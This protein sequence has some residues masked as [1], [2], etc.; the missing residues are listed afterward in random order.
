MLFPISRRD[1]IRQAGAAALAGTASAAPA[2]QWRNR[3]TSMAYR[4][5][6]RTGLMISEVVSGGDPIRSDNWNHLELALEMGLNYLDMAPGYGN[7]DCEVAYGKLLGGSSARREKVFLTTKISGLTGLRNRLYKEIFDG[8]PGARQEALR[9]RA[10]DL[11]RERGIAKP[12]YLFEY[13]PGQ[14]GQIA[15]SYLT[16]AMQPDYAHKVDGSARFREFIVKS[17]EGSLQR[18]RTDYFDIVMCPHGAL[19]PEELDMPEIIETFRRLQQQGKVRFLG[20]TSHTDP[21]G[22]LRRAAALGHYDCAM[23][24]YNV[25]NG[26][27]LEHAIQEAVARGM[28][29]VA[30][31]VAM[32]VATHHKPLQPIPQWRIDKL[33]RLIPGDEK[34]PLNAYMWALQNPNVSAVISNLWDETLVRENLSVAGRKVEL[35]PA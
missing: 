26:G 9:Q 6:G 5:L 22:V 16:I 14:R 33:N 4:R 8:L 28:G 17:V 29:V 21:A 1:L 25:L 13:F 31:K 30:M 7:G 27:Y 24:A 18:I 35:Q 19:A 32:P 23:I 34:P 20:V 11:V 10:A 12:G 3:Q 15:P 2:V